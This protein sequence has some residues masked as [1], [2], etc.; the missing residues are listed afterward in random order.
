MVG[1]DE[2]QRLYGKCIGMQRG[3]P[4]F[5]ACE[6][7]T[8]STTTLLLAGSTA[9]ANTALRAVAAT[10]VC[11]N[12]LRTD[13][14]HVRPSCRRAPGLCVLLLMCVRAEASPRCELLYL[15]IGNCT[16]SPSA[17]HAFHSHGLLRA[18][19]QQHGRLDRGLCEPPAGEAPRALARNG[20]PALV[21]RHN[22]HSRLRAEP[23]LGEAAAERDAALAVAHRVAHRALRGRDAPRCGPRHPH[24]GR[25]RAER[26]RVH[27]GAPAL[28]GEGA[29][30]QGRRR[31][32]TA[33]RDDAHRAH[34]QPRA[35]AKRAA[36]RAARLRAR[37][38]VNGRVSTLHPTLYTLTLTLTLALPLTPPL[39]R[40]AG[41]DPHGRRG[42]RVQPAA[43]AG[44]G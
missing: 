5:T 13:G 11:R 29:P 42:R 38:R 2:S 1:G 10:R 36:G 24:L 37:V 44:E 25:R 9:T 16:A 41:G 33:T 26:G 6:N 7:L 17:L 27:S 3:T 39:P 18:G 30:G 22:L 15:D 8:C 19:R 4:L 23:A 12:S 31:R 21:A 20:T 43:R 35:V 40:R 32:C 28:G 14:M 34:D